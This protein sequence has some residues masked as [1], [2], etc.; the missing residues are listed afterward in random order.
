MKKEKEIKKLNWMYKNFLL[1]VRKMIKL[2]E[3]Q[4]EKVKDET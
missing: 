2:I 3:K 1:E 4:E